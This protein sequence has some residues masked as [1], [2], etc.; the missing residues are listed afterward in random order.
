[1]LEGLGLGLVGTERGARA[2]LPD[3]LAALLSRL[4]AEVYSVAPDQDL[5]E[6]REREL[7][8]LGCRNAHVVLA[9]SQVGWPVAALYQAI[10]VGG[11]A[12]PNAV[13]GPV[14]SSIKMSA[15]A[16]SLLHL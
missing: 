1:M 6:R 12:S 11:A 3:G 10:L 5:A 14:G 15:G 16:C 8:A 7:A 13:A 4:A 9:T 2:R